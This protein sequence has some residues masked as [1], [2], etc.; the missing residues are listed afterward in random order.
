MMFGVILPIWSLL[1]TI[2]VPAH[3]VCFDTLYQ[4][5]KNEI[6]I[7][8]PLTNFRTGTGIFAGHGPG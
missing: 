6:K 1:Q 2:A 5:Q 8:N 3:A 7:L 4:E